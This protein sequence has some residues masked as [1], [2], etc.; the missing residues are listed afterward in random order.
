M[1]F[2]LDEREPI[3]VTRAVVQDVEVR[4]IDE[5][6]REATFVA[7][8]ENGVRTP[9]GPQHLLMSGGKLERYR[10]N[11]VILDSH[12]RYSI[13]S[14][15]GNA[16]VLI[17]SRQLIAKISF[18]DTEKGEL[19]WK[20][21]RGGFLRALSVGF[22]IIKST[23]IPSGVNYRENGLDI[24]GPASVVTEWELYEISLIPVPGDQDAVKR[25][26]EEGHEM[27]TEH[28]EQGA[29]GPAMQS[30]A[31]GVVVVNEPTI[32]G[33]TVAERK[34]CEYEAIAKRIRMICPPEIMGIANECILREMPFEDARK[35]MLEA[36]ANLRR[37]IGT[38]AAPQ[39]EERQG[40]GEHKSEETVEITAE[41]FGSWARSL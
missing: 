33:E 27:A 40:P 36:N 14:I 25:W 1:I 29:P 11:P 39:L 26:L 34:L 7:S 22:R 37:A 23:F 24:A 10:K 30:A 38:P 19:A 6:R 9:D 4:G 15:L 31:S 16:E 13:E 20:L 2:K 28:K 8:T 12:D 5:Q 3:I 32:T 17:E 35:A 41:S 18:A 21:V